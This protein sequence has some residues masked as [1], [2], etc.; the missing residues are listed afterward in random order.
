MAGEHALLELFFASGGRFPASRDT[1]PSAFHPPMV[2]EMKPI[3][4]P[5]PSRFL[6]DCG[7]DTASD[8][9]DDPAA[10]RRFADDAGWPRAAAGAALGRDTLP[11]NTA[12]RDRSTRKSKISTGTPGCGKT[13]A[14]E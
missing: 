3:E 6:C 5:D 12:A 7:G 4:N 9:R 14:G 10:P 8:G 13:A 1:T 11:C 2:K